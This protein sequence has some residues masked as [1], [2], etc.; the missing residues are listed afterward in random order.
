MSDQ[1]QDPQDGPAPKRGEAAWKEAKER[2]AQRNEAARKAGKQRRGTYER[3]REDARR[4]AE[5]RRT[6]TLLNHRRT[7]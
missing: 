6:A 5:N 2:I 1:A 3:Q 7:P 4:A